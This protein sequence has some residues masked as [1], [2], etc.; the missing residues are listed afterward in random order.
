MT[1]TLPAKS[2]TLTSLSTSH[3]NGLVAVATFGFMSFVAT[4]T[5]F[6]YLTYK[7]IRWHVDRPQVP[8]EKHNHGAMT[9]LSL[10][11]TQLHFSQSKPTATT[12]PDNAT[13]G[14]DV[15]DS[16]GDLNQFLL[17]VYN[18][19]FA[20]MHQSM[21]FL[22]NVSWVASNGIWVGTPT[23]WAQ[24]WFVSV[25]DLAASCFITAIAVHTYL[26]V[27]RGY[28]PPQWALY[29]T[30][31]GLWFFVYALGMLGVMITNNGRDAGGLYVRAVAWV[32]LSISTLNEVVADA[33]Y[34]V[35]DERQVR[36]FSS[37][38][39]LLLD[40]RLSRPY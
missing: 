21:A 32:S 26:A 16:R 3:Y 27:V 24:G 25:G 36:E 17:L 31:G 12:R 20:E 7:L 8:K 9:D 34:L 33:F 5:L 14:G 39:A 40:L 37:L 23:C 11:L 4:S 15:P 1:S 28:R 22:L 35:L 6:S 29:A 38:A 19:L 13:L 10:G 18:L 2:D 30:I